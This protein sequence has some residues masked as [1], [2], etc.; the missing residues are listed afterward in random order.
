MNFKKN[1]RRKNKKIKGPKV[2]L[3]DHFHFRKTE[4][5]DLISN[6]AII[7]FLY[8]LLDIPLSLLIYP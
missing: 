5:R 8:D 1:F 3:Y 6:S 4:Y 2:V 7:Y